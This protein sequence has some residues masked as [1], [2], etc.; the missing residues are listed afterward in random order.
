MNDHRYYPKNAVR[1]CS[2]SYT[3]LDVYKR[4]GVMTFSAV[5]NMSPGVYIPMI[6]HAAVR[7]KHQIP[8]VIATP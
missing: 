7:I 3:H 4:Q 5:V 8:K 1:I 6:Q 2:V